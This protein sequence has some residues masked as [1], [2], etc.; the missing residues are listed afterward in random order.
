MSSAP[1]YE[2]LALR[3]GTH[4]ART[5]AL[6]FLVPDDHAAPMPL[7][8]FVWAIRGPVGSANPRTVVV[9]TGM[10]PQAVAHRPGRVVLN[11]VDAMLARAG[12]QA[13]EVADVVLT[14]M[15][16]DHAGNLDLFPK[17]MFHIQDAEMAFCTGR[18]MCHPSL[19]M[20]FDVR[21]V[22]GAVQRVHSGQMRFHDGTTDLLPR[23][24]PG[25]TLHLLGG[26]TGGLQAV[27]VP[28]ARGWVVLASDASHYWANLRTGNPFPILADLPRMAEGWRTLEA[29]ADGPDHVI[30]G[31]D[32]LV[33]TRFP[34]LGGDA[35]IVQLHLAPAGA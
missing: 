30:P 25:I 8:Y 20:A 19:K 13:A 33:R 14:H 9:D 32:P 12:I 35:E 3:Y 17:A 7:D 23:G 4:Q 31:H 27:R 16:Y 18:C 22:L 29:L 24:M 1:V 26:H 10:T 5:A 6:N 34:M 21:D 28:T 11:T 2:V 15:H